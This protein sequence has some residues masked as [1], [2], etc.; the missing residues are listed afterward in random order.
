MRWIRSW[1][2]VIPPGRAYVVDDMERL[3]LDD[4]DYTPLG[5][6]NE[7]VCL[8]EWDMAISREDRVRF[9]EH[10]AENPGSVLVAP[11]RLYHVAPEPVWAHR[12]VDEEGRESWIHGPRQ[13]VP[14]WQD[15]ACDYFGFGLI[16][17]PAELVRAFLAAPAPERG[18]SPY[19][20]PQQ[21]YTD[22]R[23]HDQTFSI[24]HR[25]TLGRTV[26]V[27]WS[28]QPIHLHY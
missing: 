15:E 7:S 21:A 11:Y 24:W 9:E 28:V 16:Y 12:L 8:L 10:A 17:F 3:V 27:D 6:A 4:Y 26:T 19:L 18:R 1:P 23:F 2:R 5:Q 22:S 20:L 25:H 14:D 13:S